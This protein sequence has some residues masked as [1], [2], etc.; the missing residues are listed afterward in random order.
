MSEKQH[1]AEHRE[2]PSGEAFR[3]FMSSGWSPRSTELPDL[4]EAARYAATRREQVSA[5]FPGE[6]VV[7]P[8]GGLKIRS[9]DTDYVFRPHSAFAHLTGLGADREPDAVLVLEPRAKDQGGGHEAVLYFYPLAD[10][11]SEEFFADSRVGEFWVGTRPTLSSAA[12]ELGVATRHL[13]ELRDALAKDA[14]PGGVQLRV[15]RDADAQVA[16]MV[17]EVRTQVGLTTDEA[18]VTAA[19]ESDVELA[20]SLSTQR[21]VKDEWEVRQM[22]EAVQGTATAFDAVVAELPEA[23]RRGRGERWVEGV[24]GLH[25]RHSGNGVGYDSICASGEHATTLHWIRNTGEVRDGDL[26]LLDAGVETDSL[27][28]ADV[29]RTLPVNGTF[30]PAQRKVYEA[31][32]EAQE[33]GLAAARPGNR[34]KD[35]HAAAIEVI[36]RHL[37]EWGLLPEG[38]TLEQTLDAKEGQFHRRWMVHGTSHHLGID[39]HDCALALREDYVEGE[40]REGMVL[41]VE[42]GLYFKSDD[43]LVPEELRGIGVRI[44]D[45]IVIT[46]DGHRNLSVMLPR[47]VDEVEAWVREGGSRA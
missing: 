40:L 34:F 13:D 7:V 26:L 35:V 44:E 41:T 4:T 18:A 2:R 23:V 28:T 25:A 11:D 1:K 16:A 20:R 21:L 33:A 6:R 47:T 29:T 14:G 43:L 3:S 31:V 30:S 5:A 42:P 27:Y 15:V 36:A 39:V 17:D 32:L 24:F 19:Q 22:E 10:R 9:N 12:A 46:A 45:D 8:A 38:V 37:L